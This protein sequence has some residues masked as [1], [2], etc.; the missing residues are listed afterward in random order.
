MAYLLSESLVEIVSLLALILWR[1]HTH[2][3]LA[4]APTAVLECLRDGW[5]D[6]SYVTLS[7]RQNKRDP[8]VG[9][10]AIETSWLFCPGRAC[11]HIH[12]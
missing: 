10:V 9:I 2:A 6:Q 4:R 3:L 12:I 11:P 7:R 8:A 1:S 5:H